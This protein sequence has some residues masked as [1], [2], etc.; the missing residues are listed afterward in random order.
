MPLPSMK[1]PQSL[2]PHASSFKEVEKMLLAMYVHTHAYTKRLN[3]QYPD[4]SGA[5]E[6][7]RC[8]DSKTNAGVSRL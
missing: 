2:T 1:L 3:L 4:M 5:A 6:H 7:G 8:A